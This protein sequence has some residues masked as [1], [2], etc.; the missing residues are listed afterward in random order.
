MSY[1]TR[2]LPIVQKKLRT[3]CFGLLFGL[4]VL[5]N[6]S[7]GQ[8]GAWLPAHSSPSFPR[9]MLSKSQRITASENITSKGFSEIASGVYQGAISLI[10]TNN[11]E[12]SSRRE[13]A[14]I[15]K[16][17]AFVVFMKY[18]WKQNQADTLTLQEA[19]TLIKRVITLLNSI[20]TTIPAISITN[21]SNYDD[22]QWR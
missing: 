22:W 12:S 18:K 17:T 11:T 7:F 15:A 6:C 16:N 1:F 3:Y 5:V 21:P 13:R 19:D 10:P 14:R 20:N 2:I 4:S 8:T 9:I